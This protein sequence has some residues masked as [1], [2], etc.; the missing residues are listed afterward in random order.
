[1]SNLLT[2]NKL[3]YNGE[4]VEGACET[5]LNCQ[6]LSGFTPKNVWL[7]PQAGCCNGMGYGLSLSQPPDDIQGVLQGVMVQTQDGELMVIDAL[8]AQAIVDGCNACCDTTVVIEPRYNGT[9]PDVPDG[10]PAT[11]TF[12]REDD[13]NYLANY[14]A[15]MD[16][17]GQYINNTFNRN[18]YDAATGTS[19]YSFQAYKDP[20]YIDGDTQTGETARVFVSNAAPAVGAGETLSLTVTVG[21]QDIEPALTGAT[22]SA[23]TTAATGDADYN[24]LGT[25]AVQGSNQIKLTSSTVDLAV[26]VI[27]KVES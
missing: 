18:S 5:V 22:V 21:N 6:Q 4:L 20:T 7:V 17:F 23:L 25:F 14:R 15:S 1:M 9:F 27:R 12:T 13:G 24:T 3:W 16:Y 8:S 10:V 2:V 26:L 19:T 11:Y